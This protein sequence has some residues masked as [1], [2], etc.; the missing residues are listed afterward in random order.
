MRNEGDDY[1]GNMEG[2]VTFTCERPFVLMGWPNETQ[3]RSFNTETE[4]RQFVAKAKAIDP[5]VTFSPL[6]GFS[7]GSWNRI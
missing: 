4:A 6:Y 7:G 5:Y 3:C 1:T 2:G